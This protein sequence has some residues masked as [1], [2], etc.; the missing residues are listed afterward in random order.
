M[1]RVKGLLLHIKIFNICSH[2]ENI[3]LMHSSWMNWRNTFIHL[4]AYSFQSWTFY[5]F[6]FISHFLG[7]ACWNLLLNMSFFRLHASKNV[8][9]GSFT[10]KILQP[11]HTFLRCCNRIFQTVTKK[12]NKQL[13]RKKLHYLLHYTIRLNSN[14]WQQFFLIKKN[15]EALV[16]NFLCSQNPTIIL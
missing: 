2:F 7:A 6:T 4:H 12:I 13:S 9:S 11:L 14:N 1:I 3:T 15:L 5:G 10:L 16:C 8:P